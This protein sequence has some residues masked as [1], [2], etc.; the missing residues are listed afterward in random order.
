M[1]ELIKNYAC[2][3][4]EDFEI[5]SKVGEGGIAEIYKARQ[6][7]LNRPVAIKVLFPEHS[8]DPDIVKRFERE[9]NIIARLNH[10]NIVHVIGKGKIDGRYYFIMEFVD[11]TSFKDIIYTNKY[12]VRQKLDIIVMVLKGLDYAHKN[13]VIHR[14]IKPANILIDKQRN[15]LVADFG[16]AQIPFK[17]DVEMTSS[18]IIMGTMAYMSPEQKASAAKVNITSDLYS[19]GVMIYEILIGK[20][21]AGRFKLPSEINPVVPKKFD[22]IISKCLAQN[23]RDRFQ[24]AVELKDAIL[25]AMSGR[26]RK[27]EATN[28]GDARVTSFIGKCQYMDTL[29]ETKYSSTMLLENK[30]NH[31][32]YV[33]KKN[34]RGNAGLKEAKLLSGL[35]HK[36]IIKIYGAGGDI[37]RLVTVMEYASGGS[38][39]DR[40]ARPYPFDEAMKIILAVADALDFAQ[41]NGIIHGNL[42][43]SNILFTNDDTVKVTDFG[44][45]AHY[46]LMEKN[47][48][49]PPEKRVSAQ[50][51]VYSLGVILHQMLFDKNPVY[52]R[53]S[54]LFLGKSDFSLPRGTAKILEKMLSIRVAKRYMTIEEF[55]VDWDAL[56]QEI[57]DS[58]KMHFPAETI[59]KKSGAKIAAYIIIGIAVLII[60][61]FA[62]IQYG[63][64]LK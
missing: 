58:E 13:G 35:K 29:K 63:G 11:G 59:K 46:N 57:A 18:D 22:D 24:K 9:A 62:I 3:K 54:N 49:V 56:Q 51:D 10:P 61:V 48:Y 38:L 36:N 53:N 42:R 2:P 23:P 37:R 50:G 6:I 64:I 40:M 28:N 8:S 19:V 15:A 4:I 12:T 34:N 60:V 27:K 16:I 43:P 25:E 39:A 20:R 31:D 30:E 41:K 21:P 7:S 45:P 14:D 32:L 5:I 55:L 52:D 26:A 47:W 33:I 1:A 44:L 17:G